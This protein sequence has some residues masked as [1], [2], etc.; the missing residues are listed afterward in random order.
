MHD[1]SSVWK[2]DILFF[3]VKTLRIKK[4]EIENFRS[5]KK[6][7]FEVPQVCPII[8]PNNSGKSNLLEAI[9]RV[10]GVS[11]LR[12]D[13][14]NTNDLHLR[15]E[16]LD[17]NITSWF[18]PSIKYKK[19]KHADDVDIDGFSFTYT[20]YKRGENIGERRLEQKCLWENGK[21]PMVLKKAPKPKVRDEYEPILGIP[22]EVRSQIPVIY[23][24]TNRSLKEHLPSARWSMLRIIFEEINK[25]L[26]DPSQTIT[27][28]DAEGA[29]KEVHRFERFKNIMAEATELLKTDE[30]RR[31]ESS[32]KQN[33]LHQ[34]GFD[35]DTDKDKIDLY[36]NPMDSM[37]FYK[38]MDLIVKEEGFEISAQEMGTGLQNAIVL[39]I[40]KAFEETK[41]Q[42]AIILIEEPEMFLHPQKQ[43]FLNNTLRK[44]GETNQ[45]IYT[46][47]SPHFVSVP[48]YFEIG[49]VRKI[50]RETFVVFSEL[51]LTDQL[52]E[53]LIKELDPERNELFFANRL[54]LVEGDTEKLALPE[55]AKRLGMDLD[56]AGATIVEVG[57]K[58][59]LR[60]FAEIAISFKI[61]TG[62]IYDKD[63][64]DIT[65]N[66][67]E[68]EYN[69]LL[70]HF[71]IDHEF[72]N[73]W[74]LE[75][76]Y[77][78]HLKKEFGEKDYEGVCQEF[79]NVSKAIRARLI[80]MKENLSIPD[81]ISEALEWLVDKS[82]VL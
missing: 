54:L 31:V 9:R 42:G 4:I 32:I 19:F 35:P 41:K 72:V 82:Q 61:P 17:I 65:D 26:H 59:N 50:N 44:I 78:D 69:R 46:T 5:I 76:N 25:D 48:N 58:R 38:T 68:E 20:K 70:E 43:R 22:S 49:L 75:N 71:A 3:G 37:D 62:I 74:C 18:D 7:S 55:Y 81:P 28:K 51:P 57:G 66:K 8:G 16:S 77:E 33:V 67:E 47:H 53:K 13:S 24:G 56:Q 29:D 27:V 1:R 36:F 34:L 80:A 45:V 23:I 63:S 30:F 39:A 79:P 2:T 6:L 64:S 40:L 73:V 10:L 12:A 52:R 14:F 21:P 11:F 60:Q 15:D